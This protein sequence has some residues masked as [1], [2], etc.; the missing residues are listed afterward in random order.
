LTERND[1]TLQQVILLETKMKFLSQ[2]NTSHLNRDRN[3][4]TVLFG[5]NFIRPSA[6]NF[7]MAL[8]PQATRVPSGFHKIICQPLI[9]TFGTLFKC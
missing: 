9:S 6:M 8:L 2:P 7:G 4:C 5:R 3:V 1:A